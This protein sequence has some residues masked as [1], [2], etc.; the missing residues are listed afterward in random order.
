MHKTK[1]ELR[2][3]PVHELLDIL[4]A[5][6]IEWRFSTRDTALEG[7]L[8]AYFRRVADEVDR[9][10]RRGLVGSCTCMVCFELRAL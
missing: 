10:R 3:L 1:G 2:R 6:Y 9:R 8:G 4:E 7:H 5:V